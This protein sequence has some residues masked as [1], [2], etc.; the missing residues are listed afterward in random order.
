MPASL[1]AT[2]AKSA[3]VPAAASR[4]AAVLRREIEAHN[5]RYYVDDAP[6]ISDAEYDALFRELQALEAEFP[7]LVTPD[8]PTQRV[9][10][11]P[12]S[13]LAPVRHAIPMLAIRT[14]TDTTASAAAKFDARI[15]RD[16]GLAADAPPVAYSAELKFD[17]LALSL[18]YEQGQL[19]QAA[20]RGDG[21]VGEDV[22]HNIRT[23]RAI[24]ARLAAARPPPLLEVRGEVYMARK[25][26]DALNERQRAAGGKLFINPRNTA[27]GAVRQLDPGA[28]A[29][30]PLRFFAYGIGVTEGFAP[31]ATHSG[32]LDVL[33]KLGLPVNA[34]RRVAHG[35]DELAAF[36]EDVAKRRDKLPFDFVGVVYKVDDLA[37]QERLG[38]VSREPRW[39]L[40]R[41]YSA[42]KAT[43]VVEA[44]EI[45]VGRT[46]SLT[47]VAKLRPVTVGGVVVQNATL[48]N[49]EEIL[50]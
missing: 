29:Q 35:P 12:V 37:L 2:A 43:T 22:T 48:H 24:P 9:G 25:D 4:R 16:L 7:A 39:A 11:A 33:R 19:V 27:A 3:G 13:G 49:E 10:G 40:A 26:F 44:I 36:Y 38:A 41:I 23:V 30:K 17:G 42:E 5:R 34:D 14:E 6:T 50:R 18:R 1:R 15:R 47:P 28:A 32:L 31:P 8:S 45:Q 21:E 20:T 46:G